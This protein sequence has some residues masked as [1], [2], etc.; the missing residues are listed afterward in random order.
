MSQPPRTGRTFRKTKTV[1]LTDCESMSFVNRRISY[2]YLVFLACGVCGVC[3][4]VHPSLL[5]WFVHQLQPQFVF[6]RVWEN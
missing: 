1:I 3:I 2:T 6:R 5:L 4:A